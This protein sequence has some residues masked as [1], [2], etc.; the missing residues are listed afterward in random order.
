MTALQAG[1]F[2]GRGEFVAALRHAL[3]Q[4][5]TEEWPELFCLDAS[6][7]DWP[8]SDAEVLEAL[9]RWA[10]A[11]RRLHLLAEQF[12]EVRRR[13]PRFVQWRSTWGHCVQALAY[14]P[15]ALAAVGPGGP[16]ALFFTRQK[17][18]VSKE[19][20]LEPAAG[21]EPA[22]SVRLHDKQLWRGAV[23]MNAVDTLRSAEYFDALAQ[24]CC[25]SFAS[26]T[27]GL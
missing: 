25:E 23:S 16:A 7:V 22:L 20:V 19:G 17:L 8:W 21:S 27:L 11:G 24:R 13:H 2:E 1:K 26:T 3:L 4:A 10:R 9:K 6:F 12:E 5:C 15:E 14:G 18:A